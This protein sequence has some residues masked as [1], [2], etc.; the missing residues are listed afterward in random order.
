MTNDKPE[1]HKRYV[2]NQVEALEVMIG[3]KLTN[4][5]LEDVFQH[6]QDIYNDGLADRLGTTENKLEVF[7]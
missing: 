2:R 6:V 7:I 4:D 3:R 5:E 1:S